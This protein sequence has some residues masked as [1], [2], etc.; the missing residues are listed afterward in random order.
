MIFQ[1]IH[2]KYFNCDFGSF[3]NVTERENFDSQ[4]TVTRDEKEIILS[5]FEKSNIH[6]GN[7][8]SNPK[9]AAKK[10][11]LYPSMIQI[12]LNLVFPK[13]NKNELR[14]YLSDEKGF[15]PKGNDIWFVF[16]N[17]QNE[18][19]IGNKNIDDWD[20][21]GLSSKYDDLYELSLEAMKLSGGKT[22]IYN[23][24]NYVADKLGVSESGRKE[25]HNTNYGKRTKLGYNLAWTR[26]YLKRAGLI[27]Q[28]E[29]T[30]WGLTNEGSVINEIDR[31][32]INNLVTEK[33]V[34]LEISKTDIEFNEE[35]EDVELEI[36]YDDSNIID[37][38]FDPKKVDISSRT[39][40]LDVI[41]KRLRNK[42]INLFTDFQRKAGLWNKTKQ[43]R[44]IESILIRFPLP[45]FY[46]DGSNDNEWLIVDGLQRLTS[47]KNF[48]E[49]ENFALENLEFLHQFN[50][51]KFSD[52]PRDLQRRI[53]EFEILAY[54]INPG[55]P[56]K[57]KYNVFNRINTGGLVLS[58][59]EIRH[60]LNQGRASKL[61]A[62]LAECE[63]FKVATTYSINTDRM[64]D[65]D[66]ANRFVAFYINDYRDYKPDLDTFLNSS[67]GKLNSFNNEESEKLVKSFQKSMKAA[68]DIFGPYAFRKM[69]GGEGERRKPIN[70][71]LFEVWSVTLANLSLS[72][73]KKLIIN[74]EVL[75][76]NFI[77]LMNYNAEFI[78]SISSGTGGSN[79][80]KRRF[81]EI[82]SIVIMTLEKHN[83]YDI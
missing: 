8:A 83:D 5:Y 35:D 12:E 34:E 38:P 56:E 82:N 30:I 51:K 44:L 55:T 4:I 79:Q 32:R 15:K 48:V 64:L 27:E 65:R 2:K 42:E 7:K 43:S 19:V 73:L 71:A 28:I 78:H 62:R 47:L 14:L 11:L 22:S 52:L 68:Y 76:N 57:V 31:Y 26:N 75:I 66:F 53:E 77:Y 50:G 74:K 21:I 29:R 23:I 1:V 54:V 70:K 13:K 18:L 20:I 60:A 9:L 33:E 10:F 25:I 46:F 58:S 39:L 41:F 61:I 36:T 81:S 49:D 69:Y 45:A 3:S 37:D 63:E 67:M 16:I 72:D 40:I 17:H 59:Q 80:V 24:E 6:R